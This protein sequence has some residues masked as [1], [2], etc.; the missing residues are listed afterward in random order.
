MGNDKGK[1]RGEKHWVER[2]EGG[3]TEKREK[4]NRRPACDRGTMCGEEAVEFRRGRRGGVRAGVGGGKA[5]IKTM[6]NCYARK[7]KKN[8]GIFGQSSQQTTGL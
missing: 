2:T 8:C 3:G 5:P 6:D 1:R 4:R 7:K